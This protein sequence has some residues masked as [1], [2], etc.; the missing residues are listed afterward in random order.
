MMLKMKGINIKKIDNP[1][2]TCGECFTMEA[3]AEFE[4]E[5]S[6]DYIEEILWNPSYNELN[7]MRQVMETINFFNKQ[8]KN[9]CSL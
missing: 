1:K 7:C 8:S 3:R 6:T 4:P 5:K 2:C 9:R